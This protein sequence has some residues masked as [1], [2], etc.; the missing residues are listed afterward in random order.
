MK[1]VPFFIICLCAI[2]LL[3][4]LPA[5]AVDVK[6]PTASPPVQYGPGVP[7]QN[8]FPV[9]CYIIGMDTYEVLALNE[10]RKRAV[11]ATN[12]GQTMPRPLVEKYKGG[13][14]LPGYVGYLIVDES[15]HITYVPRFPSPTMQS[16]FSHFDL[17][18]PVMAL[19]APRW[20]WNGVREILRWRLGHSVSFLSMA[21]TFDLPPDPSYVPEVKQ[22]AHVP[23]DFVQEFM[24]ERKG[25]FPKGIDATITNLR[26]GMR[27]MI[28]DKDLELE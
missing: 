14:N 5:R 28:L 27:F 25:H 12:Q 8:A 13:L 24:W 22:T 1:H 17:E 10:E 6:L 23:L 21:Y 16:L 7:P 2:V 4:P 26:P 9:V 11:Y 20:S 15:F 3:G 19:Y 18:P